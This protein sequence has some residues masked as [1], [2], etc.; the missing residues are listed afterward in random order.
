MF[1]VRPSPYKRLSVFRL[2]PDAEI[3]ATRQNAYSRLDL[4]M[5]ST[6]HSAPGL[7]LTYLGALPPQAGLLIDGDQLLPVVDVRQASQELARALPTAV[8][9]AIRPRG[10]CG[11]RSAAESTPGRPGER[12][13]ARHRDRA[14][15]PG[16]RRLTGDLREWPD[17][18]TIRA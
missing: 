4:V 1:E 15:R 7:S 3:V 8:A 13:T 6:I 2:N 10:A 18:P 12:R 11:A 9:Y 14:E 5:S 16:L 17:W